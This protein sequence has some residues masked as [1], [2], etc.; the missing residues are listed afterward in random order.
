MEAT[1]QTG[2]QTM[3]VFFLLFLSAGL[4]CLFAQDGKKVEKKR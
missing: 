4:L 3:R 1:R 2:C